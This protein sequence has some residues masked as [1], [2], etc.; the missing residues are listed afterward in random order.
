MAFQNID[1]RQF[2]GGVVQNPVWRKKIKVTVPSGSATGSTDV[3]LNGTLRR[4]HFLIPTL[5]SGDTAEFIVQDE[6]ANP[7]YESSMLAQQ[8]PPYNPR[9]DEDVAGTVTFKVNTSGN[10]AADRIFYITPYGR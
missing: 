2:V 6:D 8:T 7:A 9:M 3:V 1:E 5:D 10:Q 4:T